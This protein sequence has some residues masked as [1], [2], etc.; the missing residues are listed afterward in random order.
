MRFENELTPPSTS[1]QMVRQATPTE[2]AR[3]AV[4]AAE[5]RLKC[6]KEALEILERNP[7]LE[8]LLDIMQ[9]NHI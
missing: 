2:R 5:E 8:R 1:A 6:A 7:D 4:K 9:N 3:F